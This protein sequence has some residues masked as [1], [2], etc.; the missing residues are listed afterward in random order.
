[1]LVSITAGIV[2]MIPDAMVIATMEL[3]TD[4]LTRIAIRNAI[5]ISGR[6]L[7]S[8]AGPIIFPRPES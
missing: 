6:P 8:R 3:P 1:M 7:F 5:R 4:A 2:A